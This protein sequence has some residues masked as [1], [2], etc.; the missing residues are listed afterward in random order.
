MQALLRTFGRALP[1]LTAAASLPIA[2]GAQL[3]SL[4]TVP[5]ASGDQFL[6]FPSR[7]LGMGGLSIALDDTLSGPFTNPARGSRVQGAPVFGSPTLY[8]ISD[9]NGAGR[10]LPAGAL[11]GS[12][13]WFGGALLAFQQIVNEPP[14]L[15]GGPVFD[16]APTPSR[17]SER[18]SYNRYA[19]G[20]LGRKLPGGVAVA[21]SVFGG[22][23]DAVDGVDLLYPTAQGIDQ[24]GHML[25]YR[26]GVS[27]ETGDGRSYEL[28]LLHNRLR[29][30]HE[31]SYLQWGRD[32]MPGL[33]HVRMETNLDRTSTW[34]VHLR[35]VQP[36]VEEGTRLGVILTG[37]WKSHPKIPNYELANLPRDPGNSQ[38][39]NVGVG[40]A[41]TVGPATMGL[42]VVYE[43]AWSDTWAEADTAMRTGSGGTIAPGGK[44]VENDFRFSNALV[45]MGVGR[46]DGRTGFQ[47]GL[48]LRSVDYR[49]KQRDNVLETRREQEEGWLEWTPTWGAALKFPEFEVRYVGRF[50][51]GTGRPGVAWSPGRAAD[52][53]LGSDVLLAPSG[54]LTLQESRVW[55]HQVSV[56]VPLGRSRAW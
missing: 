42:D 55:M 40:L 46:E 12:D 32:P 45:R 43:P 49:L 47:L 11:F 36:F 22:D 10:T 30:R 33:P 13:R 28:L 1:L 26:L 3:I 39:Y 27:R 41:R 44:T 17:L 50:T 38:A 2:A 21:G 29:M 53:A 34:G 14:G 54:P 9:D 24:D 19:F 37:N 56:S 8:T 52:F 31:V 48:Q 35:S 20:M 7:T 18:S 5:I 15:R 23:L 25:D 6:V 51:T 4:K 16:L